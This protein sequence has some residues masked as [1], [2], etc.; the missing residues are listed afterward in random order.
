MAYFTIDRVEGNVVILENRETKKMI[1][2]P[3]SFLPK[4]I[5]EGDIL[6]LVD[7]KFVL[8]KTETNKIKNKIENKFK[9]LLK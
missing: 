5:K 9:N 7:D 1:E 6:K 3:V 8:D 2:K 4:G